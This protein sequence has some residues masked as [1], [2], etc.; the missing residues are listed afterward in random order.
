MYDESIRWLLTNRKH[1][2]AIELIKKAATQ[3][4]KDVDFLVEKI[5]ILNAETCKLK[6]KQSSEN[7]DH[8]EPLDNH[9]KA[10]Y[11]ITTLLLNPQLRLVSA[12]LWSTL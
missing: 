10:K 8:E 5:K 9:S 7:D 11:N 4:N 6:D 2:S 12:I 3:N 1:Q